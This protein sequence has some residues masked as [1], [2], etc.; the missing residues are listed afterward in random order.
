VRR[1]RLIPLRK[2]TLLG[3]SPMYQPVRSMCLLQQEAVDSWNTAPTPTPLQWWRG[4]DKA[5][6]CFIFR[7]RLIC[8]HVMLPRAPT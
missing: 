6:T 1:G 2:L 4:L 5:S 8:S 7:R 3:P